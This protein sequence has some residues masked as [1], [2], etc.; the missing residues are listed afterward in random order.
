MAKL[1]LI[2][3]YGFRG[4][5]NELQIN[6]MPHKKPLNLVL[7]GDNGQG[8][9]S[10]VDAIEWFFLDTVTHLRKEGCKENAYRHFRLPDEE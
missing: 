7:T 4:I 3:I 6:L 8:K 5:R 1:S 2:S 9:S 10:L